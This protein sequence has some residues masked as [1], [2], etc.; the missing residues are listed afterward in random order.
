M[1]MWRNNYSVGETMLKFTKIIH[2]FDGEAEA[3]EVFDWYNSIIYE[4]CNTSCCLNN[5]LP[6]S[7]YQ[8]NNFSYWLAHATIRRTKTLTIDCMQQHHVYR[9][10]TGNSLP[11][12]MGQPDEC[13]KY[14]NNASTTNRLMVK[15]LWFRSVYWLNR[16]LF[17]I[18]CV[19][20]RGIFIWYTSENSI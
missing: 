14:Q 20:D 16:F 12:N 15:L 17:R 1:P 9:R 7:I 10:K 8:R 4:F 5:E 18:K 6:P 13:N 2:H 11:Q 19:D 3:K